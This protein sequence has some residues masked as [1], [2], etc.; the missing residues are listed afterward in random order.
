MA[1]N[2]FLYYQVTIS[3]RK[4]EE[5]QRLGNE[6]Q[7][8]KFKKFLKEIRAQAKPTMTLFLVGG[9]DI[10]ADVLL[11]FTYALINISLESNKNGM[12]YD[13]HLKYWKPAFPYL[14]FWC[15]DF[16]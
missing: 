13:L 12:L 14:K 3:N 8:K 6:E 10:L 4:A 9:I 5:N 7:V 2:S 1:A 15:M 16:I 11:I